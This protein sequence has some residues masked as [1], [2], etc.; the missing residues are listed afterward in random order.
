MK[1]YS[2]SKEM[3]LQLF[4]ILGLGVEDKKVLTEYIQEAKIIDFFSACESLPL[5]QEAKVKINALRDIVSYQGE[6]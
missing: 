3:L 5:T 1:K 2:N 6:S 4:D